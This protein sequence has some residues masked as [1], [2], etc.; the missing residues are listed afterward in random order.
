M[1]R[2]V[3]QILVALDS[4]GVVKKTLDL[5]AKAETQ[6]EQLHYIVALRKAKSGWTIE[7]RKRYF[8]WFKNRS[9]GQDAGPT[10]PAGGNYFI[11]ASARHPAEFEKWFTDV[12]IKAGNGASY[13]NFIK[14][15]KTELIAGLNDIER[16]ELGAMLIETPVVAKTPLKERQFVRE[17]K[18]S[19][20]ADSLNGPSRA[21]SYDS[22][23]EAFAAA[24]KLK[25]L[26]LPCC[27][28][29]KMDAMTNLRNLSS[30][31]LKTFAVPV[32]SLDARYMTSLKYLSLANI[33][34]TDLKP[35]KNMVRL[36]KTYLNEE[37][38][39][40]I[41]GMK[42]LTHLS[43]WDF[44]MN[45]IHS[46]LLKKLNSRSDLKI[47]KCNG[48]AISSIDTRYFPNIRASVF[49]K[50]SEFVSDPL[51]EF[52]QVIMMNNNNHNKAPRFMTGNPIM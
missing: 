9:A 35:L 38:L 50:F 12:G 49:M 5:I 44:D 51:E 23:R 40:A 37:D 21:R 41:D 45:I 2:E 28:Q 17:W 11:N 46:E 42:N 16:A 3:S 52:D 29:N 10:Y 39:L 20:F 18:M 25:H 4:P 8:S 32:L 33:I 24:T 22:G 47:F 30:L 43:I 7:D 19:D 27:V 36:Q 13:N 15:L 6:E 14:K 1:N 31:M 34:T 48:D 26:H